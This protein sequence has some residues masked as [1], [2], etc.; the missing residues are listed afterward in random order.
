MKQYSLITLIVSSALLANSEVNT[1]SEVFSEA[2]TGGK[3]KY[4]YIQTDKDHESKP[5]TSVYANSVGGQLSFDTASLYGF[6][7]GVT[8][9][10]T[11]PFLL[12]DGVDTSIIGRDNG[13][14]L[15]ADLNALEATTGF[16]V[17]GEAYLAYA[18]NT[19][20][21]AVGRK[22]I[23]TPLINAKEARMIP[24]AVEGVF[25]S[26]S[27]MKR[28]KVELAYLSHF[29]QRTSNEFIDMYEHALGK[30]VK[31]ITGKTSGS[32][33]QADLDYK[34]ESFSVRVCNDYAADF[35]NSLYLDGNY[36][37][38]ISDISLLFGAE[39][40]NQM[41]VGNADTNLKDVTLPTGGKVIGANMFGLK[42]LAEIKSA[43]F[44][45]MYTNVLRDENSHDSLVLPWDGTPLFTNMIT[46]NDFFQSNYGNALKADTIYIGGAQGI[47]LLYNQKFDALGAKGFSTTLSYLN[48][49]FGRTDVSKDQNDYNIIIQYKASEAFTLQ[50]KGIW[51]QNNTT[52]DTRGAISQLKQLSQY[53]AIANYTF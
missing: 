10:T 3:I 28:S 7:G 19:T 33:I 13:V 9:M 23:N 1:L 26:Y 6:S 51:V 38:G 39:Y 53:R 46:S 20:S 52:A 44:G 21:I 37:M 45:L 16:S 49:S 43:K 32:V 24:S 11:N 36:K 41:S 40:I 47:K 2:K 25:A 42:A 31:A 4:Y 48:T 50:L 14:R 35:M 18:Y 15:N 29:K 8:F 17:L 12:G 34:Y 27:F 5:S 30:D 22:V